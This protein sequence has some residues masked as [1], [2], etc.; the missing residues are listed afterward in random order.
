MVFFSFF[1]GSGGRCERCEFLPTLYSKNR[2]IFQLFLYFFLFSSLFLTHQPTPPSHRLKFI[3]PIP[4]FPG[5]SEPPSFISKKII[6]AEFGAESAW[7]YELLT[8]LHLNRGNF[9][10]SPL[11]A[12]LTRFFELSLSE[13]KKPPT[14]SHS[15]A[16]TCQAHGQIR[17]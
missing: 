12:Q 1:L 5:P 15:W 8:Y 6:F 11:P 10:F 4:P 14:Q 16:I 17:T 3:P 2:V 7:V 9:Y 13:K